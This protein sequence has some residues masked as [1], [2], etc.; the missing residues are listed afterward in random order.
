MNIPLLILLVVLGLVLLWLG[1]DNFVKGASGLARKLHVSELAVGLTIVAFGTSAPELAVNI[2][3]SLAGNDGIVFGNIIGSN[4]FNLFMI[5][6][7]AGLITPVLVRSTTAWREIPFSLFAILV[8]A[9]L[10]NDCFFMK[11]ESCKLTRPDALVMLLLFFLFLFYVF[12]QL[13][14]DRMAREKVTLPLS[15]GKIALRLIIGMGGLLAG[16]K[17]VPSGAIE[18]ALRLHISEK[19]IGMTLVAAGTSLPELATTV[20]AALRRNHDIAVGNIIG[21]NIFNILCILGISALVKPLQYDLSFNRDI[22]FLGG[23]NILLLVAMYTGKKYMIERW[24]AIILLS[25]F[26]VYTLFLIR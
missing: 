3:A 19:V 10:A 7:I 22:L 15:S 1:A 9:F 18:L 8:L 26:V 16:G 23:G 2:F 12:R 11:K 14:Q 24:E 20:V 5:L 13:A 25:A 6:S 17:L 21:S 4:N